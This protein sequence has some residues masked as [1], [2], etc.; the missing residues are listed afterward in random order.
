MP[1]G[2]EEEYQ[3]GHDEAEFIFYEIIKPGI[4]QSLG[5]DCSVERESDKSKGGLITASIIRDLISADVVIVDITGWNPNVFLE[6]GMRYALRNKVT[7]VMA[8]I[9]TR[10]P[11]DIKGYRLIFYDRFKPSEARNNIKSFIKTGLSSK[12]VS[13]SIVFDTFR[14]LTVNNPGE[15]QSHRSDKY[16]QKIMSWNDFL[17]RIEW[18]SQLLRPYI[19]EGQYV[20]DAILGISNGGLIVADLI[21]KSVFSG[22]NAPILSLW[23]QRFTR[24]HDYFKNQFNDAIIQ[25]IIKNH[26]LDRPI[27]I[28]LVDDHFGSGNTL[29]QAIDYLKTNLGEKTDILFIPLVSRR[30]DHLKI[31]DDYLPFNYLHNGTKLFKVT[32]NEFYSFVDTDTNYFPYLMK[33]ISEGLEHIDD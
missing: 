1:F 26:K 17:N 27:S 25:M 28:F 32:E 8:Q 24:S 22:K 6:L 19:N 10:I 2:N 30:I 11:F 4:V 23:A 14:N 13:D 15:F 31:Y 20:P 16:P 29:K 3:G 5:E 21:G 18:V 7:I 33:Q 9:G 12:V